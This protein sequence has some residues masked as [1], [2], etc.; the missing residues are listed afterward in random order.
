MPIPSA[1]AT[2]TKPRMRA[3]VL[4]AEPAC[5]VAISGRI[6][7]NADCAL[8]YKAVLRYRKG[9]NTQHPF[10]TMHEGEA[11]IR[12]EA[13]LV[14][15][16]LDV[17]HGATQDAAELTP[18]H[19]SAPPHPYEIDLHNLTAFGDDGR[20]D[21]AS[22]EMLRALLVQSQDCIKLIG[23]DG[24]VQFMNPNGLC[25]MEI[26]DER[27]LLGRPWIEF[28]P[29]EVQPVVRQALKDAD[30]GNPVRFEALCP[31]RK[32]TPRWWD[33]SLSTVEDSRGR[34]L[35][36]LSISR[37]VTHLQVAREVADIAAADMRHRLKNS[38]AMVGGLLNSLARGRPELEEFAS[39]VGDRLSALGVS[40]TLFVAR[41][42]APCSLGELLP[43]LLESFA[44]QDCRIDVRPLPEALVDQ[45]QAD[46]LALVVGELAVNSAK[47]GAVSSKGHI[48]VTTTLA[49]GTL[50]IDWSERSSRS[51]QMRADDHEADGGGQGFKLIRRILAVKRGTFDIVW[52]ATGLDAAIR[53]GVATAD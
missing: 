32:G 23:R 7:K 27:A 28:W 12:R 13:P 53:L 6:T 49:N 3:I 31:T 24:T 16:V 21:P 51:V 40:Q 18:S 41:C 9:R 26:D 22:N 39:D 50:A 29:A 38:Y 37:D 46:A 45:G 17:L 15:P 30:A 11:F 35:G 36:Y 44:H 43:A 20:L 10:A 4:A 34:W 52:N 47:H 5:R 25:A 14:M 2:P 33:V 42:G 48:V 8:P 19:R 1:V